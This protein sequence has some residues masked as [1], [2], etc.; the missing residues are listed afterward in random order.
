[1]VLKSRH[2]K[3]L[4]KPASG[5]V[6]ELYRNNLFDPI[7]TGNFAPTFA[8]RNFFQISAHFSKVGCVF[9]MTE[10]NDNKSELSINAKEKELILSHR[11][12]LL[13]SN[14]SFRLVSTS[15]TAYASIMLCRLNHK[16]RKKEKSILTNQHYQSLGRFSKRK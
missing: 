16:K 7:N 13:L 8:Y 10:I 14:L 6:I 5:L 3:D 11:G 4:F 2:I 1:M 15:L 12:G 9:A